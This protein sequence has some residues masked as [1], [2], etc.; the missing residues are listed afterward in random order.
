MTDFLFNA[1][2]FGFAAIL[3]IIV[4][5]GVFEL[6]MYIYDKLNDL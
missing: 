3:W 6:I 2:I 1:I 5:W 4:I